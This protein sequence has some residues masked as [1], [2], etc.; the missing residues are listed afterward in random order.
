[1][2]LSAAGIVAAMIRPETARR[3]ATALLLVIGISGAFVGLQLL[4]ALASAPQAAPGMTSSGVGIS[5]GMAAYGIALV[6]AGI[7]LARR[8]FWGVVLGV[9][10]IGAGALLLLGLLTIAED[11]AVLLGGLVI[12]AVTLGCLLLARSAVRR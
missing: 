4:T 9:L 8:R 1:M 6:V 5:A 10:G 12:W 7:G 2:T 3:L 11:D